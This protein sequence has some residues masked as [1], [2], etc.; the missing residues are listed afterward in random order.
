MNRLTKR[1]TGLGTIM[2]QGNMASSAR[3]S[4]VTLDHIYATSRL[5]MLLLWRRLRHPVVDNLTGLSYKVYVR[6]HE[7]FAPV[8]EELRHAI[9][10][11]T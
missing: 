6:R 8:Q 10:A 9:G 4:T 7:D 3:H 1:W 5:S 2:V 11:A